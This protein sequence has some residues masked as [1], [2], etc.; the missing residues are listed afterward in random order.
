MSNDK[1]GPLG[2]FELR[3]DKDIFDH[4]KLY[5]S[6]ALNNRIRYA[7]GQELAWFR[8]RAIR[9]D[10]ALLIGA[11]PGVMA[12]A[13]MEGNNQL[14][15]TVVDIDTCHYTEAH[16][17]AAGLTGVKFVV[18]DS[19]EY[20]KEY[21]GEPFDLLIV[22]GDHTYE[23]VKKDIDSWWD[24]VRPG[25][26]IFFHDVIVI[27]QDDT[28]GVSAAI[29]HALLIDNRDMRQLPAIHGTCEIYQKGK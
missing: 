9:F 15:L 3:D 19:S 14:D 18:S 10:N 20:G 24:H 22:D 8:S 13:L 25:G 6:E 26:I 1:Y 4:M 16:L 2:I 29:A 12:V 28:N 27:N 23:G 7:F 5:S 17:D 21:D 11:G